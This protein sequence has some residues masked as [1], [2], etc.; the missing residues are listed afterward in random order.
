LFRTFNAV[1][2][3]Q[4]DKNMIASI[5]NRDSRQDSNQVDILTREK[6]YAAQMLHVHLEK[7][8]SSSARQDD[9]IS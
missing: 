9:L 7:N 2:S 1:S 3:R 4:N 5:A 8:C 6:K